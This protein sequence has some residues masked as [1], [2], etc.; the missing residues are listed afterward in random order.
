LQ[1]TK[2][3]VVQGRG[4]AAVRAGDKVR[5]HAKGD[6]V[7]PEGVET[8]ATVWTTTAPFEYQ[9]G[10]GAVI[11]GWDA[12]C[13]GMQIGERRVLQIPPQEGYGA[14]GFPA[15]NIPG[16]ATLRFTLD[17]VSIDR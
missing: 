8:T 5:V 4:G 2:C 10:V 1:T 9:A 6:L 17:C 15:W 13:L 7:G 3:V 11:R 14:A 16:G 12:G